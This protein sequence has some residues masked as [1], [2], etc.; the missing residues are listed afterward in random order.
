MEIVNELNPD[1]LEEK[2]FI[3]LDS[4]VSELVISFEHV[5]QMLYVPEAR[6]IRLVYFIPDKNLLNTFGIKK[7]DMKKKYDEFECFEHEIVLKAYHS[8]RNKL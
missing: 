5:E 1:T 7:N 3:K 2:Y 8:C 4:A 6:C